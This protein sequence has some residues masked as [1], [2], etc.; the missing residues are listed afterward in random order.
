M[1]MEH[2]YLQSENSAK[3]PIIVEYKN[4]LYDVTSFLLKHPGSRN[5]NEKIPV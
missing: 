4:E 2:E 3:K 1:E 5:L